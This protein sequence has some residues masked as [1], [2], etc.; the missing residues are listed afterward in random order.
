LVNNF[1]NIAYE[2]VAIQ[3]GLS[4]GRVNNFIVLVQMANQNAFCWL[5]YMQLSGIDGSYFPLKA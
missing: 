3:Y 1:I 2:V 5:G 4:R